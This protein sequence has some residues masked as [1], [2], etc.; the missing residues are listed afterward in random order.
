MKMQTFRVSIT[1]E[2]HDPEELAKAAAEV[3]TR[4]MSIEE[5][6][7]MRQM[8]AGEAEDAW[9]YVEGDLLMV[10]DPSESLPGTEI[11]D[12]TVEFLYGED[13]DG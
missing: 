10:L 2:V 5:W 11:H 7:T 4:T 9:D 8:V 6:Q 1:I 3:A 12:S 13:D